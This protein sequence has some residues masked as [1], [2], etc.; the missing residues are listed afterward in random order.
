MGE[1]FKEEGEEERNNEIEA[2][3]GKERRREFNSVGS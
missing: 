2:E 1:E 3:A